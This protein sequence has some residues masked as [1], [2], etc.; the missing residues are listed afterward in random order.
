MTP[1]KNPKAFK[2]YNPGEWMPRVKNASSHTSTFTICFL[3]VVLDNAWLSFRTCRPTITEIGTYFCYPVTYF[4]YP[5]T[6]FCYPATYFCYPA[7]YFCYPATYFCYRHV[8][9]TRN[10]KR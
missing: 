6:Y 4:C 9:I 10:K 2:R 8:S 5:V 1:D 7:T 3:R